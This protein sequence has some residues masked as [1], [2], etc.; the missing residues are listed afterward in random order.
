MKQSKK[1]INICADVHANSS[2][3]SYYSKLYIITS[4]EYRIAFK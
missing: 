3:W 2:I 4:Y 1:V